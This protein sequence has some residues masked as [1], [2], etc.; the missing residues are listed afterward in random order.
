MSNIAF[1]GLMFFFTM[2]FVILLLPLFYCI[3]LFMK[4]E[5]NRRNE[6]KE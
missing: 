6:G 3:A 4:M 1:E 2:F 5:F